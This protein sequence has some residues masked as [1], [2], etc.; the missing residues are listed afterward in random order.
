MLS[1]VMG[2]AKTASSNGSVDFKRANN[3]FFSIASLFPSIVAVVLKTVDAEVYRAD[4]IV[5]ELVLRFGCC[6]VGKT[7]A[8]PGT[9]LTVTLH[10]KKRPEVFMLV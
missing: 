9:A 8:D 3:F 10:A 2:S 4:E 5:F 1:F 7:K 6:F